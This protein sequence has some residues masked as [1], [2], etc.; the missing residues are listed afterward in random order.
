MSEQRKL[1]P[2][3]VNNIQLDYSF[4][5]KS[6]QELS[7]RFNVNN[8]FNNKYSSNAY[9]GVWYEQEDEKTWAYYY[10]QAGINFMFGIDFR[11]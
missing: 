8:I 6:K 3:F 2:Y 10:P 9:G 4:L 7:L 5:L 1:D 11:F